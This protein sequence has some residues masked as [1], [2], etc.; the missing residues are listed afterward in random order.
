MQEQI[1]DYQQE[2]TER[3]ST[4]V[5]KLFQGSSFYKVKLD[6]YEMTEMLIELFGRLS[7]EEMRAIKE[8]DL[9]RR[10]GKILTLEAVSGT[11]NDLSPE[12]IAIFDAAVEGK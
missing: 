4:L 8:H 10:I 11:L 3:I 12:E 9:S 7:P 2:L 1:T 5:D 6:Q